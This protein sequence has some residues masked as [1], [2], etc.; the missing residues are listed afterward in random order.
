[1]RETRPRASTRTRA[2]PRGQKSV[3]EEVLGSPATKTILS[4]IVTGIFGTRRRR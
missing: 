3:L 1:M 2:T 4:G